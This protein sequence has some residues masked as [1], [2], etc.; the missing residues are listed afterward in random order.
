MQTKVCN[1]GSLIIPGQSMAAQTIN[2]QTMSLPLVGPIAKG[3]NLFCS[4]LM[5]VC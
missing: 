2:Q 5:I 1:I 4:L 3:P